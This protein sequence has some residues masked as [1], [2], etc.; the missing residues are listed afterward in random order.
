MDNGAVM[1]YKFGRKNNWRR[2]MWNE[3]RAHLPRPARDAV[4]LY[5]AG[6]SDLDRGVAR[7]KGFRDDNLIAVERN[8]DVVQLLRRNGVLTIN[9]DIADT[10][11]SWRG[12]KDVDVVI[13]DV[14]CGY[15]P[16]M[17]ATAWMLALHERFGNAVIAVNLMRGR[18]L[19]F[20]TGLPEHVVRD[21]HRG[22]SFFYKNLT[23]PIDFLLQ[24]RGTDIAR[25]KQL[26]SLYVKT[27]RPAYSSYRSD[28]GQTF[29]SA[30]FQNCSIW[31]LPESPTVDEAKR[32]LAANIR[33]GPKRK[34]DITLKDISAKVAAIKAHRTMRMAA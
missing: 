25:Q 26:A 17:A 1:D 13:A 34:G 19:W 29:D 9:G 32:Y 18:E 3:V 12:N 22:K 27:M 23:G 2:W 24:M 5:L 11:Y 4:V 30:V 20:N 15:T 21:N 6:A 28:S 14:C 7:S 8:G 31:R 33:H 16:A 10:I